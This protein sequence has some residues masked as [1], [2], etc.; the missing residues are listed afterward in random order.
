MA[1]LRSGLLAVLVGLEALLAHAAGAQTFDCNLCKEL[2]KG[3]VFESRV[4][5]DLSSSSS[6]LRTWSCSAKSESDR[7]EVSGL[8]SAVV[9]VEGLPVEFGGKYSEASLRAWQER[10]CSRADR[11]A[12]FFSLSSSQRTTVSSALTQAFT[13]CTSSCGGGGR[14]LLCTL[15][16]DPSSNSFD[17][18]V[19]YGRTDD[20]EALPSF[21]EVVPVNATCPVAPERGAQVP[22]VSAE[23]ITCTPAKLD[24]TARVRVSTNR[25]GQRCTVTV[26][27]CG[28]NEMR[29]C[30]NK[31]CAEGVCSGGTCAPCGGAGE[32]CCA[33]GACGGACG[34][35]LICDADRC[36]APRTA[37]R[38]LPPR[39]L[40]SPADW[41]CGPLRAPRSGKATL[42]FRVTPLF[43][44]GKFDW[45]NSPYSFHVSLLVNGSAVAG[46]DWSRAN[47]GEKTATVGGDEWSDTVRG[48]EVRAGE[49]NQVALRITGNWCYR[50][51]EFGVPPDKAQVE[52]ASVV[53]DRID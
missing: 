9:P 17:V 2:L 1:S 28:L 46:K 49:P 16:L 41:A 34:G 22:S 15:A 53:I 5:I 21:K 43:T 33:G 11:D 31:R 37:C 44:C 29:C 10:Q 38:N 7:K 18:N 19:R 26:P 30:A 3:G 47:P 27:P 32:P 6:T 50:N 4:Q 42:S 40:D 48:V 20:G 36:Q 13:A 51:G 52:A 23:T 35:A 14:G 25:A 8:L 45:S 39:N 12:S 24:E